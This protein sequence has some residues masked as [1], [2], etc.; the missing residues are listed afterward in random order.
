MIIQDAR[1][2]F[3]SGPRETRVTV[4]VPLYN[5][6]KHI[7]ET[8]DSVA[9][10]TFRDIAIVVVDDCSTDSSAAVAEAWMRDHVDQG[11]SLYLR[12]NHKN[13]KLSITRNTGIDFAR[14]EMCFMLDADNVLYPRCIETHVEAL[15]SRPD[16]SAAYSL[17]EV[18]EARKSLIGNSAFAASELKYGNYIDAMAMIR[19][20]VLLEMGGYRHMRHGWEDYELWLRFCEADRFAIHIPEILSRYREHGSSMLRTQTNVSKNIAE[21]HETISSMHPWVELR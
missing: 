11:L 1:T 9:A 6:E 2:L 8:L 16:A 21:V 13:A 14:S 7:R 4:V 5:Y 19:R 15:D 3:E 12:Q 20:D 10:Q 17:I 18:F